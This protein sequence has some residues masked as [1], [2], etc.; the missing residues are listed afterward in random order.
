MLK[1]DAPKIVT[2]VNGWLTSQ[3]QSIELV[4]SRATKFYKIGKFQVYIDWYLATVGKGC[5]IQV[6]YSD[7]GSFLTDKST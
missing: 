5:G 3:F 1:I 6:P 7:V 4:H 2:R